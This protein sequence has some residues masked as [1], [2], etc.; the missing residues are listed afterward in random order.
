MPV[1][2]RD[3][4]PILTDGRETIPYVGRRPAVS[5]GREKSEP[6]ARGRIPT[7]GNFTIR[8]DF[9]GDELAEHWRFVR[10]PQE[11][12]WGVRDG[13]LRIE[14]R[15]ESIGAR[16]QPSFV[17]TPQRHQRMT[18]TTAVRYRPTRDGDRA[19]LALMQSDEH[20][21]FFGLAREGGRT[22]VRLDKRAGTDDPVN[23]ATV[24]SRRVRVP[25]GGGIRLRVE[26][27][28]ADYR[29]LFST[30]LGNDGW[31]V[32]TDRVDGRILSTQSAG[33]FV[34]ALIGPYAYRERAA[35]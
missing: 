16:A 26:A 24:A 3:G 7:A 11:Q 8:D 21:L 15:P 33:G 35:E 14:A 30:E 6:P 29:F 9:E 34:G 31:T 18:A 17:G 19:G 4:W 12:W 32:L 20:Y 2:W 10:V 23:A 13:S 22:V 27:D 28:G 5:G 1:E 25:E